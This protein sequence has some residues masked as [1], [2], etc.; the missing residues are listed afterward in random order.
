MFNSQSAIRLIRERRCPCE[1]CVGTLT[2]PSRS[3]GGW[4]FCRTCGCAW[5]VSAPDDHEY[6]A[7]VP[8]ETAAGATA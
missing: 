7:T 3:K 4:G 5:Q 2:D 1:R 8:S 6:A